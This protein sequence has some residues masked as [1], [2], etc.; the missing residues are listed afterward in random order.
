V[1]VGK[2][3]AKVMAT[4]ANGH[5][6]KVKHKGAN[7]H[8]MHLF[9]EADIRGRMERAGLRVLEHEQTGK[10]VNVPE[11]MIGG[12]SMHLPISSPKEEENCY[13]VYL[14]EVGK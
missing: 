7:R 14:L 11:K 1:R 12:H 6:V 4:V 5:C 10:W 9:T 3:G 13:F 2:L 8:F